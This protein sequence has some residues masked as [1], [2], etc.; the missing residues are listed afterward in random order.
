MFISSTT[1][2]VKTPN[3]KPHVCSDRRGNMNPYHFIELKRR[4]R[5]PDRFVKA[6]DTHASSAFVKWKYFVF[7]FCRLLSSTPLVLGLL[8]QVSRGQQTYRKHRE[9]IEI[10]KA[11]D[12]H[13]SSTFVKWKY[14]V[15]RFCRLLPSTLLVLRLLVQVP[16]GQHTYRKHREQIEIITS[17]KACRDL[18]LP[19]FCFPN[20]D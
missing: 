5:Y 10:I 16:R 9:Q 6:A 15:F 17:Y 1:W 18:F 19:N 4:I 14:F 2:L 12:A 7:R 3:K 20:T 13:A 8:V 11:A